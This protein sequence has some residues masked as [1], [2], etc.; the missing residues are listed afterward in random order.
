MVTMSAATVMSPVHPSLAVMAASR[1]RTDHNAPVL[2]ATISAAVLAVSVCTIIVYNTD[3]KIINDVLQQWGTCA[4]VYT[5]VD[6]CQRWPPVCSQKC[7]NTNGSYACSCVSG[8]TLLS[9]THCIATWPEPVLFYSEPGRIISIG[10]K[11]HRAREI[12][13]NVPHAVNIGVKIIETLLGII[14]LIYVVIL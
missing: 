1:L 10:L 5:E 7:A 8:Y 9:K 3:S 12:I 13:V 2:L 4:Y 11:Q 14:L 6:E